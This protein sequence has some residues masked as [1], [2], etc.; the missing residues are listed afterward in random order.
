MVKLLRAIWYHF[1]PFVF[2]VVSL[3]A[4][5]GNVDSL[6]TPQ[7]WLEEQDALGQKLLEEGKEFDK[8]I[9]VFKSAHFFAASHDLS[10][11]FINITVGY[12]IA[13]YRNGDIQNSYAILHDV[14]HKMDDSDLRL[15]AQVN[16]ILGMTLVFKNQFA[17]GYKHQMDALKFYSDIND[18][19]GLMNVYYDL[20]SN[21]ATQEQHEL[22]LKN[23]EKGIKIAKANGNT[24]MTIFGITE[25]GSTWSSMKD[26]DEALNYIDEAIALSITISDDEELA[27]ASINKG[28]ILGLVKRYEQAEYYLHKAYTLSFKIRNKL[29]TA[30]ALEQ[31]SDLYF[32]QNQL[33]R[34]VEKLDESYAVFQELGQINSLKNISKKYA[35]IYFKQKN[36]TKYKAYTDQYIAL[37]DSLYSKEMREAIVSLEQDFEIHQVEHEK[38]IA[39]LTKDQELVQTRSYMTTSITCGAAVISFLILILMY[40]RNKSAQEKNQI[41]AAKN[42]EI[43]RQN[44]FLANSNK[45]LEKFAYI[46][47]HDLKEP[48]RNINGFTNLLVKK[49]KQLTDDQN[50]H[51]YASF[52]TNGTEQMSA[53]LHGLLEYS[54]IGVNKS[55]K[56]LVDLNQII[57]NVI[58]NFRIQLNEKR[59]EVELS[60]LP[61]IACRPTQFNQV[62]QNL[63]ANAI[64]FGSD[65]GN[66][67][68][69]GVDTVGATYR[70]YVKDK[71]IGI[72][73]EY[74][75]GIFEV[76][77]RLHH[78]GEYS[79][80]GIGLAT[81]KKIVE[82]HGG[83][84]WVDSQKGVGSCFYFTVPIHPEDNLS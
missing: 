36:F 80:S 49:M 62:F 81:C 67:I 17:E 4:A 21:F 57:Q 72:D 8:A 84:I 76:F 26:Y 42:A 56:E 38:E 5:N 9:K 13:L 14:L 83:S 53:L 68:T 12:G 79:G 58:A 23:Y 78:R 37:K 28:H 44:E 33:D 2:L 75:E 3:G 60:S 65:D 22:A 63:I 61:T 66:K 32:L 20:G 54:K 11:Q 69:V 31:M 73:P 51:E 77:K 16:Q 70:F 15:K 29:L 74:Q 82:D 41:L 64:K 52:I 34:A 39:L 6:A 45:D 50:M 71:G 55:K 43:L 7:L 47:S 48:L 35:E 46:I 10:D 59:C 25:I 30:Y 18:S 27:W 24:K 40:I 19:T 1:L